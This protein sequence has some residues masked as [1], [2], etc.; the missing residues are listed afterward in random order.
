LWCTAWESCHTLKF[1]SRK[2]F[3]TCYGS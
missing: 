1:F 2:T 3:E